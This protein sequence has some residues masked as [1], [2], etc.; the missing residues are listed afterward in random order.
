MA[1]HSEHCNLPFSAGYSGIVG[2]LSSSFTF[3]QY[4]TRPLHK[5]LVFAGCN[6]FHAVFVYSFASHASFASLIGAIVVMN[7]ASGYGGA[8]SGG[9][10]VYTMGP[11]SENKHGGRFIS[12]YSQITIPPPTHIHFHL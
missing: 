6:V 11:V 7:F 5:L 1:I 12:N 9:M 4:I 10:M 2:H 8:G 3:K